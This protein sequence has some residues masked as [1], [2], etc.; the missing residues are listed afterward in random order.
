MRLAVGCVALSSMHPR[1]ALGL[2]SN[3]FYLGK[4]NPELQVLQYLPERMSI[5]DA[6]NLAVQWA[7]NAECD[8]F[9]WLDDDTVLLEEQI[10]SQLL[11]RLMDNP[12][13]RM[14]SPMY[15]VRG[16][17]FK[18]MG[19]RPTGPNSAKLLEPGEELEMVNEQ[20]LITGLRVIGNGCTMMTTEVVKRME[21]S[22][23]NREWY[24]TQKFH[25]EDAYFCYKAAS[26]DPEFQCAIDT[27]ITAAHLLGTDWVHGDNIRYQRLK[28]KLACAIDQDPS[29]YEILEKLVDEWNPDTTSEKLPLR[30]DSSIGR[31]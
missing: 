4:H 2:S 7:I 21:L 12:K 24:K 23:L 16:Y 22:A 19:F 8:Y 31:V 13:I 11:H 14:I 28:V 26:V 15:F 6:R 27:T 18:C 20:G 1:V 25:T 10:I 30:L 5:A 29:R 17:P 9:F 3:L